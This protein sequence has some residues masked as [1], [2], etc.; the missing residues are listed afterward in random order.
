[1][2]EQCENIK[3]CYDHISDEEWMRLDVSFPY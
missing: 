2:E 3:K 1:M